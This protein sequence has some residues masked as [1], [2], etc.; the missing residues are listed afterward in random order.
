MNGLSILGIVLGT[1]VSEDLTCIATGLLIREGAL[2]WWTGSL[3]CFVGIYLGD[4]GLWLLGYVAGRR[5]LTWRWVKSRLP[6]DPAGRLDRWFE[7]KGWIAILAARFLPGTRLPLY[8]VAGIFGRKA[9]RFALWTFIAAFVWTP[10]LVGGVALLGTEFVQFVEIWFG[11]GWIA[12]I[13]TACTF[14]LAT[15]VVRAL[16]EKHRRVALF[17]KIVKI[18]HWEYW[19]T[20]IFYLPVIPWIGW[21]TL[22]Y[23][24]LTVWTAANP[25][26][27]DGG[28]VGESKFAILLQLPFEWIV[29]SALVVPA[30]RDQR[31]H[32]LK[33]VVK[34]RAWNFPLVLKPDVGQRGAGVKLVWDEDGAA[35][36]LEAQ[37]GAVIVQAYHPGPYEAGVFYVRIPGEARGRIFSIT[38]KRFPEIAGDG[39]STLKELI[40]CHRRFR[41][42]ASTFLARHGDKANRILAVGES[43]RLSNAG[44]HCQGTMFLDGAHL[45]TPELERRFDEIAKQFGGFFFGRFDVRYSDVD[46]F[47]AGRNLA[48]VELNGVTSE[49]T[50]LY[51]PGRSLLSAYCVLYQQWSLLF[52]IGDANRRRGHVPSSISNLIAMLWSHMR[53]SPVAILAD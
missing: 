51:D 17:V 33:E 26:I 16:A 2:G 41:M 53:H 30:P 18:W 49:S 31:V 38:D 45:W 19:P 36:Y 4:L 8:L 35:R 15:R 32:E 22:R 24:S 13:V 42:Q 7:E 10:L 29:P 5:A 52:R 21:L 12:F 37:L 47:K 40:W 39:R 44:N 27:P 14:Y 43:F 25:G 34:D 20:W 46:A 9:D 1:F 3:A 28:V 6:A 50:N 48:I 23:R 11:A